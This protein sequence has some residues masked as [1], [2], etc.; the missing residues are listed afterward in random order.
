MDNGPRTPMLVQRL[1]THLAAW[2]KMATRLL[3]AHLTLAAVSILMSSAVAAFAGQLKPDWI[4]I[5]AFVAALSTGL[6]TSL[7]VGDKARDVRNGWR[8]MEAAL[9]RY[10][11]SPEF[12]ADQLIDAYV[13]GERLLGNAVPDV[14]E[15]RS[16]ASGRSS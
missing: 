6:L 4:R 3:R 9:L 1:R 7:R 12:T 13:E 10:Q 16:L 5:F 15:L 14:S 11:N 2:D 8:H